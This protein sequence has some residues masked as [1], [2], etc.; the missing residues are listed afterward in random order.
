[1][2]VHEPRD[3]E[4]HQLDRAVAGDEDVAW[5]EIAMHHAPLVD[6]FHAAQRLIEDAYRLGNGQ[7]AVMAQA[8]FERFPFDVFEHQDLSGRMLHQFVQ[9]D[10]VGAVQP[11][12]GLRLG[13]EPLEIFGVFAKLR[14]QH[15]QRHGTI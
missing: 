7:R 13:A 4:V 11:R 5:L 2:V 14:R 12:L 8:V 15:L 10:D 9:R 1:M 6:V 3:S